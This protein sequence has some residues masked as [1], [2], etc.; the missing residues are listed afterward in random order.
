[1]TKL[2]PGIATMSKVMPLARSSVKNFAF[3]GF[4]LVISPAEFTVIVS[5][6]TVFRGAGEALTGGVE[7]DNKGEGVS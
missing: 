4:L 1:M 6:S 3:P 2:P 5:N 7:G